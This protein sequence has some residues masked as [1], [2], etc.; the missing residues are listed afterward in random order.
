M[1]T[2]SSVER[3][4]ESALPGRTRVVVTHRAATARRADVVVWLDDGR[5]R[6]VGPHA[7]LWDDDE[8]RAV[9]G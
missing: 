1:V 5:V 2:E 6:A 7:D 4:V 9:F 3:A 8:Y